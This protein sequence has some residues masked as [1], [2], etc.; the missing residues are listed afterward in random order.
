M[1]K[2]NCNICNQDN[3]QFLFTKN[4]Y[5][6]VKC[7]NCGLIYINPIERY[8]KIQQI[9]LSDYYFEAEKIP[10]AIG[11]RNYLADEFIIRLYFKKQLQ[12]IKKF[13]KEGA[14]LDVGCA[15]GFFLDEAGKA[16]YGVCGVEIVPSAV[17]FA[18]RNL[19]LNVLKTT[20]EKA[21]FAAGQFDIVTGFEMIEHFDDPM[22]FLK[23]VKF[24]LK[25]NGFLFLTT[26]DQGSIWSK[27][28]GRRWFSYNP[29]EHIYYFNF[30]T[31]R[32]MLEEA[33]FKVIQIKPD[34]FRP[35]SLLYMFERM[36]YYYP[37][38][39]GLSVSFLRFLKTSGHK[40][41]T[42]PVYLGQIWAIA[43]KEQ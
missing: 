40:H 24:I 36:G 42:L 7:K 34:I 4:N 6:F 13:K 28:L 32:K 12:K 18:R 17:D 29:P 8:S 3:S 27:L 15:L 26:P 41:L 11:Y 9:Y 14:L 31:L 16:E 23:K 5:R 39:R 2:M 37:W 33:G 10:N 20:F 21:H 25:D 35:Y 38:L 19:K 43:Q 1:R 30:K 22:R